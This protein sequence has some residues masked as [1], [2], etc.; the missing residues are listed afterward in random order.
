M[1]S[2]N[3]NIKIN[4]R[5][6]PDVSKLYSELRKGD[7]YALSKAITLI[8]SENTKHKTIAKELINLCLENKMNTLRIGITGSPG[9]GKSTLLESLG[10]HIINSGKKPAVLAIDPSSKLTSGSILGDKTRMTNLSSSE[11]AFIRPSPAGETLGGVTKKSRES[12][13]LTETANYN[14]IFIETVGVGQSEMTVHS[15]TDLF[16][17]LIQ[18]GS[19]DEIQGIKRGVMEMADIIVINKYDGENKERAQISFNHYSNALKLFSE[20]E[21][22]WET[23]ILKVSA[24]EGKGID[25]LWNVIQEY[26]NHI[27][28]SKYFNENRKKQNLNWFEEYLFKN[29]LSIFE[30][31]S[32]LKARFLELKETVSKGTLS[33]YQAGDKLLKLFLK[34]IK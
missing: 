1:S 21:N 13:L 8:E 14:P 4:K 32:Y 12:I 10:M 28:K 3:P 26:E 6:I 24:L 34:N 15:M 25:K 22:K 11:S 5:N 17:L 18:P 7:R 19:G 31:D 29:L 30:N 23:R 9:V 33:P 27:K 16:I 2:F 20:K